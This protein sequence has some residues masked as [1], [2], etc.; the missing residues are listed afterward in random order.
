[1]KNSGMK[2]RLKVEELEENREELKE[3]AEDVFPVIVFA[4]VLSAALLF[5]F[6]LRLFLRWGV[7]CP[8]K[9]RLDGKTVIVTV[10]TDPDVL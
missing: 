8:S 5:L 10:D 2:E 3:V 4:A 7:A 6:L 9:N 1:M